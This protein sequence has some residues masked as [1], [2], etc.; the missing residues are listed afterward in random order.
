MKLFIIGAGAIAGYAASRFSRISEEITMLARGTRLSYLEAEGVKAEDAY[1]G[2]VTTVPV[3]LVTSDDAARAMDCD[4][5]LVAV[6]ADEIEKVLVL[7]RTLPR[8]IPIV[9]IG[10]FLKAPE[11]TASILGINRTLFAFPGSAAVLED[12][13]IVTYVD[14]GGPEEENW[15]LTIG[16][17]QSPKTDEAESGTGVQPGEEPSERTGEILRGQVEKYFEQAGLPVFRNDDMK[18]VFFSQMAV[19]LPIIA[20]LRMAGGSLSQLYDRGDLLKL[21]ILGIREALSVQSA[22]GYALIPGSLKLYRWVPVFVSANMMKHRFKTLSSRIGIEEFAAASLRETKYLCRELL[23]I[24]EEKEIPAG[25][26]VY[27]FS[28][29][30][31]TDPA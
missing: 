4:M 5:V 19:R 24:A 14:R 28:D 8:E 16:F 23:S 17:L 20:A 31:D 9:F 3:R 6:P 7:L 25:H 15:G 22:G 29:F 10:S 1:T 26:L 30:L 11:E 18:S 27:L 2:A 13:G 12:D 21:M